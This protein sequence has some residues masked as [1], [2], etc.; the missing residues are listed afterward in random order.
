MNNKEM[1]IGNIVETM[2]GNMIAKLNRIRLFLNEGR[3]SVMVGAGFSRNAEKEAHVVMKDWNTLAEDIY[4]QLYA[5]KPTAKD[6][7]FKTPMRLASLLA[8]NVGRSGLDQV[9]KDSLPDDLIAPSKLHYQLMGLNWRDVFT[10]NYD[11]LLERA[12]EKAGRYYKVVTSKEML[13]YKSS[14]RIIKLH[15]SFPDKT[16]FLMTE[17]EFRTYP[18]DHP[19]F[20]NTVRQALVESVFCLIGFSGDDPNFT[21][22]QAWLRDVMGDYACPTYLITFDE[23]YDD[24]FKKLMLSRGIEVLNLAEVKG[25]SDYKTALEF[26]FTYLGQKNKASWKPYVNYNWKVE[27]VDALIQQMKSVRESYPG[28]FVLPKEY[29]NHFRDMVTTFPCFQNVVDSITDNTTKGKLLF[30]LDWRA[31]TSLSLKDY[32]WYINCIEGLVEEYGDNRYSDEMMDLAISLLRIYRHH[33]EKSN[34][35]EKLLSCLKRRLNNMTEVH[36]RRYYYT[37]AGNLLSELD[38]DALEQLLREWKPLKNDYDGIIYKALIIAETKGVTESS[39][40]IGEALERISRMLLKESSEELLS[41]KAALEFLFSFYNDEKRPDIPPKY[42]FLVIGDSI[43]NSCRTSNPS[44]EGVEHGFAIGSERKTWN[45]YTGINPHFLY[46]YRFLLLC[47]KYGLPYGLPNNNVDH[48][49]ITEIIKY[50][51]N[52]GIEYSIPIALRSGSRKVTETTFSRTVLE[53]LTHEQAEA[54]ADRFLLMA[55]NTAPTEAL[56]YRIKE[57][58]IPALC[59]LSTKASEEHKLDVFHVVF[60]HFKKDDNKAIEDVGILY[61]AIKPDS[62]PSVIDEVFSRDFELDLRGRDFPYPTIGYDAFVPYA[63]HADI[64]L[65]GLKSDN[66][67]VILSVFS[68]MECLLNSKITDK[69]KAKIEKAVI[70][71]R[72]NHKTNRYYWVSFTIVPAEKS[73]LTDL[74]NGI[75]QMLDAILSTNYSFNGSSFEVSSLTAELKRLTELA[76]WLTNKQKT[77]LLKRIAKILCDNQLTISCDNSVGLMGGMHKFYVELFLEVRKLVQRIDYNNMDKEACKDLIDALA[78]FIKCKFPVKSAM[79]RLNNYSRAVKLN[80]MRETIE[81]SIFDTDHVV[82]IDSLN[83]LVH[84]AINGGNIQTVYQRIIHFCTTD[85]TASTYNYIDAL[86]NSDLTKLSK[87][88]KAE[89]GKMMVALYM[90]IPKCNLMAEYKVDLIHS[91]IALLK[92]VQKETGTPSIKEASKLWM[93]YV[94]NPDVFD[95]V[96]RVY[97]E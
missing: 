82:M 70:E 11:T 38:Y 30:E 62:L 81:E 31:E 27:D 10:T 84:H 36:K 44:D 37:L 90:R 73:E 76:E 61:D 95:D 86:A 79:E 24:S 51:S 78:L 77:D 6:L 94:N 29:Y 65:N 67:D 57:V 64:V 83:A 43:M 71:W 7:A 14:P 58:L 22:W 9:I 68:R 26:F 93:E 59:R 91:C 25:L 52:F 16:P 72:K 49:L 55:N 13:L 33:P 75:G 23:K 63:G 87:T 15:G 54:M 45:I 19:E 5:K 97:Y 50:L 3:A 47:E 2:S 34:K 4:V 66:D 35:K 8:A 39:I 32:D 92:M 18:A 96:K 80:R 46:P 40:M 48:K 69:Q 60:E 21:S 12:A 1:E 89:L 42:S 74:R 41:R 17:E 88:T 53:G 85:I 56:E 28:W 20:V